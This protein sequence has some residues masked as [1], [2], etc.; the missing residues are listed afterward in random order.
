[1]TVAAPNFQQVVKVVGKKGKER[2]EREIV[3]TGEYLAKQLAGEDGK[4]Y[5]GLP[6]Q[7]DNKAIRFSFCPPHDIKSID[8]FFVY[9]VKM[10][11][12][13]LNKQAREKNIKTLKELSES[14]PNVSL[15]WMWMMN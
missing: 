7:D 4:G 14:T 13:E 1:M 11:L 6:C 12:G 10:H 5:R 9:M 8:R 2:T 3:H 15:A